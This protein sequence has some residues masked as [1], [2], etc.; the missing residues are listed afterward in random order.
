MVRAK[1]R[2]SII[3]KRAL[4][5]KYRVKN[6]IRPDVL[7]AKYYGSSVYAWAIFYANNIF[8]P[9]YDWPMEEQ[10]FNKYLEVKYGLSYPRGGLSSIHHY[11]MYDTETKETLIIDEET[12]KRGSLNNSQSLRPV[13]I[14]Q[15]EFELNES[16]RDIVILEN[17]FL[18]QITNE[19][20]NIF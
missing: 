10:A 9:L 4:Y 11:E 3:E 1:I 6:G 20:N 2:D 17:G 19:L 16:K 12:F 8:H 5:Y 13:T 15:Y 14:Y 7:S 18:R